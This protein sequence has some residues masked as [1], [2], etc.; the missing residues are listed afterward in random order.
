MNE[1]CPFKVENL[2][3]NEHKQFFLFEYLKLP[4]W[5][6]FVFV[7]LLVQFLVQEWGYGIFLFNVSKNDY[8]WHSEIQKNT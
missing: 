7:S 3:E 2:K 1:K 5:V 6:N 4:K 8:K